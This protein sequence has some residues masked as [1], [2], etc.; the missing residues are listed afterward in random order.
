MRHTLAVLALTV[1]AV[2]VAASTSACGGSGKGAPAPAAGARRVEVS[3]KSF[4]F[5]PSTIDAKAGENLAIALTSTDTVH[6]FVVERTDFTLEAH[7]GKTTVGGLS[8][9]TPGTYTFYC[10]IPGHRSAGMH[11]TITIAP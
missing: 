11:G 10:S 3:A 5:T 8:L 2:L 9:T 4:E 1:L 7:K 6:N